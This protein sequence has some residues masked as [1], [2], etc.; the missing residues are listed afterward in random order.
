MIFLSHFSL[1]N[2]LD[3]FL[4]L[5]KGEIFFGLNKKGKGQ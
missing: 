4:Y 5:Y 2:Y 1:S 3:K